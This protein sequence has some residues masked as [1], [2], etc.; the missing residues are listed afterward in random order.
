M[1][2]FPAIDIIGGKAVRLKRGDYS[3]SD[4]FGEPEEIAAGFVALGARNL[5]VVDL[6]GAKSGNTDNYATVTRL[7]KSGLRTEIGGGVRDCERI[8]RYLD[9]GAERVILGT[10]AIKNPDFLKTAL[11]RFGDKIAVG[12]DAKCGF[13]ATDGWTNVTQIPSYEF[14]RRLTEYGATYVIYTD[15][16]TDGMLSGTN[17]EAFERLTKIEGLNVIASGGVTYYEEI[18]ALKDMGAYGVILGKALYKGVLKLD[19][20]IAVAEG[21]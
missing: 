6:D 4:V 18:A 11:N 9:A 19:R 12:V 3:Q 20:A 13:V 7:V 17:L 2:I 21:R 10:A 1:E 5:H 15:I 14:C 16:D 8:S